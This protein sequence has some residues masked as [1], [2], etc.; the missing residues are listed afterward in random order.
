MGRGRARRGVGFDT[1][2]EEEEEEDA[3][4]GGLAAVARLQESLTE[5]QVAER[6]ALAEVLRVEEK[7]LHAANDTLARAARLDGLMQQRLQLKGLHDELLDAAARCGAYP[8]PS[9]PPSP[10]PSPSPPPS[11]SPS[12]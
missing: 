5:G 3:L 4:Y 10:S 7:G 8:S 9:P 12:P 6:A 2:A 11:P 1:G